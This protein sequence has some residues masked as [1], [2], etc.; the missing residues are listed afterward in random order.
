MLIFAEKCLPA[1]ERKKLKAVSITSPGV[2]ITGFMERVPR[3]VEKFVQRM[4]RR[5]NRSPW[6]VKIFVLIQSTAS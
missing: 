3:M 4:I 5:Q 6:V 1:L 2:L